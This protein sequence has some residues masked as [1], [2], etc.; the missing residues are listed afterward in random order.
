MNPRD[1]VIA[2][3]LASIVD[4]LIFRNIRTHEQLGYIASGK[5]GVYPGPAGAVQFRV[6]IQ[7][8]VVDPDVM[9]ARL[10]ALLS[11]IPT[12][13]QGIASSEISERA[14]GVAAGLEEQPTSANIE[15]SMFWQ[16]IHDQSGCFRRGLN[17]ADFLKSTDPNTL[18]A[19]LVSVFNSFWTDR[20]RK[21]VVKV[22][23]SEGAN[24]EVSKWDKAA[25]TKQLGLESAEVVSK[26]A[27]EKAQTV[28]VNGISKS[29]RETV[30]KSALDTTDPLWDP[31]VP[32][33]DI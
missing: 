23:R 31:V 18:R 30:F 9:E 12:V 4:P 24:G 22:F 26:L 19:S 1:R 8:N 25:L 11:T 29:N 13:L 3:L 20:R 21:V 7:G 17:Q 32:S 33:C 28:T 2:A 5:I 15:V 16:P 10:E 14:Q 27:T 6:Y